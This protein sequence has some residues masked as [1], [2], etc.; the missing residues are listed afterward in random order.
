[1]MTYYTAL[2]FGVLVGLFWG[3][4]LP[5]TWTVPLAVMAASVALHGVLSDRTTATGQGR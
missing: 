4:T 2:A 5:D 1:M 3:C